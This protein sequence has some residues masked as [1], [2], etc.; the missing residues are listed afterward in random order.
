MSFTDPISD[1]L[2][3][4]RNAY[5]AKHEQVVVPHSKVKEEILR[6][7][8]EGKYIKH[9]E[10]MGETK[11]DIIVSLRYTRGGLP[12]FK[13]LKRISKPGC[14]RYLGVEKIKVSKEGAGFVIISTPKGICK[15]SVA[16]SLGVGGEVLFSIW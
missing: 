16:K 6:V 11:K 3:R 8:K 4:I 13:T 2:S 14:R 9:F 10:T 1:M 12:P 15:D 5:H 7:L